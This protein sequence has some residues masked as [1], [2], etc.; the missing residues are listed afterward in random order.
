VRRE[1]MP[2]MY[3]LVR[4]QSNRKTRDPR[5]KAQSRAIAHGKPRAD[6]D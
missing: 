2:V 1:D 5:P 6:S 4:L 3:E